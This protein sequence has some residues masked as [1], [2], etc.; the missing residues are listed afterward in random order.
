MRC[1]PPADGLLCPRRPPLPVAPRCTWVVPPRVFLSNR[2]SA[3]WASV[4]LVGRPGSTMRLYQCAA[5]RQGVG[6][7]PSHSAAAARA[8]DWRGRALLGPVTHPGSLL[9][10]AQR[11]QTAPMGLQQPGCPPPLPPPPA[12]GQRRPA[13]LTPACP[14][15]APRRRRRS[16]AAEPGAA[17]RSQQS[18]HV[19]EEAA[20]PHLGG[21]QAVR[22]RRRV[23]HDLHLHHPAHRYGQGP[24][25]TGREGQPGE[26]APAAAAGSCLGW[27]A[28][29]GAGGWARPARHRSRWTCVPPPCKRPSTFFASQ[30]APT[31]RRWPPPAPRPPLGW[32]A[33]AAALPRP[34]LH[35]AQPP[36]VPFPGST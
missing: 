26:C 25:P 30:P 19:R 21:G 36:P 27:Q 15:P 23:W 14:L 8:P 10:P 11:C 35:P 17:R 7:A 20:Q 1:P 28:G 5:M 34:C 22:Q 6:L 16:R 18:R 31:C 12:R 29:G 24:H 32:R 13:R 9:A 3:R 4:G 33:T 2:V